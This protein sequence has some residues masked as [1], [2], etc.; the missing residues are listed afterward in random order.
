VSN[1]AP[2]E[3]A[4]SLSYWSASLKIVLVILALWATVS[5]GCG[6]LLRDVLDS[7]LPPVGGAPFGFWM[8]QQGAIICFVVL[9]VLYMVLMNRL[10]RKH[11]FDQEQV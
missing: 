5:L 4:E 11:G 8:A 9:L 6:I 2:R 3:S 1:E 10:D 7:A